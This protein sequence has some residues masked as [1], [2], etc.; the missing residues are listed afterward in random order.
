MKTRIQKHLM[1]LSAV[2]AFGFFSVNQSL[3]AEYVVY[4]IG[5]FGGIKSEAHGINNNNDVV[6][7]AYTSKD[8][9]N[10]V[11]H[12]FLYSGGVLTDLGVS[13]CNDPYGKSVAFKINDSGQIVGSSCF[14]SP[15]NADQ[16]AF[17][18]DAGVMTCLGTLGG[19][20]SEAQGHKQFRSMSSEVRHHR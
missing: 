12:A 6:G 11:Y 3:A 13:G 18:Y 15:A 17:L 20:A 14:R 2:M 10:I 5:T 9:G 16:C 7:L 19:S 1:L 4:E 8:D